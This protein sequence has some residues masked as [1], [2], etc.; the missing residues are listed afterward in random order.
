MRSRLALPV[1]ILSLVA[2]A[3]FAEGRMSDNDT[4][5]MKNLAEAN[6]AE[7]EA[8]KLAADKAQNPQVKQFGQRMV[9]DHGQMLDELKKLAQQKGVELPGSAGMGDRAHT[10]TLR[11]KSGQDFDKA[12]MSDMVKDHEKD[13]KETGELAQQVG[14]PQLKSAI[15]KAHAK[16]QEHLTMARQIESSASAGG[17]SGRSSSK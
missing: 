4:K 6:L 15:Q 2:S 5:A 14:D 10:L 1:A 9:K 7:I 16:I 8:G 3:A 11:T 17:T 12:Y 13:V